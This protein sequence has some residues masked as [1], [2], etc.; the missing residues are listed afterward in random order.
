MNISNT[1]QYEIHIN[2][3]MVLKSYVRKRA[4]KS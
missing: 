1:L 2:D 4:E 3:K